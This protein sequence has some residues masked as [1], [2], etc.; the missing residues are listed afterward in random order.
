VQKRLGTYIRWKY[1]V[2]IA[3]KV[4]YVLL[5]SLGFMF[6]KSPAL[7]AYTFTEIPQYSIPLFT[8]LVMFFNLSTM[9]LDKKEKDQEKRHLK[10][11]EQLKDT[12]RLLLSHMDPVMV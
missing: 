5:L 9:W 8:I 3:E 11:K 2:K 10:L 4:F 12:K 1:R 7:I 6:Y